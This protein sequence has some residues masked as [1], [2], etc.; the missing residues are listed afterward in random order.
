MMHN[1]E[2][3]IKDVLIRLPNEGSAKGRAIGCTSQNMLSRTCYLK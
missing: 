2:S 3:G 1:E